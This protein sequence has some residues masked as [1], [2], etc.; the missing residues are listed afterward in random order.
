MKPNMRHAITATMLYLFL[1]GTA[2]AGRPLLVDDANVNDVGAGHVEIWYT[3]LPHGVNAWNVAPAYSPIKDIEISAVLTR[4]T[5]NKETLTTAQ[6]KWRI[7]PSNPEG[8]N[9]AATLGGAHLSDGGGNAA[10]VNGI[11]TCNHKGGALS[12]NLGALIPDGSKS[13]LSSGIAYE[14]EF[15]TVT[16][17]VEYFWQETVKPIVQIGLR[18][19]IVP[20]LQLDGTVGYIDRDVAFSLGLKKSF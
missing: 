8:C 16:G 5:T 14:R 1:V 7:T 19:E 20:K 6:G 4:D 10:Y 17:H 9:L 18:H 2:Y 3:H 11:A 13:L 12:F 15:G